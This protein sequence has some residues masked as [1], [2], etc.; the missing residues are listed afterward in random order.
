M[1][2]VKLRSIVLMLTILSVSYSQN[3]NVGIMIDDS[4]AYVGYTLFTPKLSHNTYLINN[5]GLL[6]H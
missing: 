1:L 5:R 2:R 6:V 4:S 3:R